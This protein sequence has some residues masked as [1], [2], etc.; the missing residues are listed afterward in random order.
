M[1]IKKE[2]FNNIT[3][4]SE[5]EQNNFFNA[6]YT[7][8]SLKAVLFLK[9]K[10]DGS[11]F[12]IGYVHLKF[13]IKHFVFTGIDMSSLNLEILNNFFTNDG[14]FHENLTARFKKLTDDKT[15]NAEIDESKLKQAIGSDSDLL[16]QINKSDEEKAAFAKKLMD[17]GAF[18]NVKLDLFAPR[19]LGETDSDRQAPRQQVTGT[20]FALFEIQQKRDKAMKSLGNSTG[21]LPPPP[22]SV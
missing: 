5:E 11:G 8:R 6:L 2:D 21:P 3:F 10:D 20:D 13:H 4:K 1:E 14:E 17:S 22:T 16:E 18:D 12:G 7:N 19:R 15:N 9:E